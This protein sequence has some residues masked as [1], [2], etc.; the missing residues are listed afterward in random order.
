MKKLAR[1]ALQ[2]NVLILLVAH[3]RKNNFSTNE[4]DE[5]SGT[6]DI[7]N[8]ASLVIGY[9]KD[10]ELSNTY[11]RLTVP[12]NRLFGRINTE[13]FLV[14]YDE[15]SKRIYGDN[16]N[17]NMEYGWSGQN[18]FSE[19][20]QMNIPFEVELTESDIE[21]MFANLEAKFIDATGTD[22]DCERLQKLV[23]AVYEKAGKTDFALKKATETTNK[24]EKMMMEA[25]KHG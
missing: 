15:R 2:Y 24:I 25:K 13:G 5:V 11:R 19:I 10:R 7:S 4:N 16:D 6:G 8:L 18:G 22:E 1:M 9:S 14:M 17:L 3:K 12:K 23:Q 21:K 20:D